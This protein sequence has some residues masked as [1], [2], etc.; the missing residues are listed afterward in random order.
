MC[1]CDA[2][3]CFVVL[4][5]FIV[6]STV[7]VVVV[8]L[9]LNFDGCLSLVVANGVRLHVPILLIRVFLSLL[10]LHSL[11]VVEKRKTI[12]NKKPTLF[13]LT[14]VLVRAKQ[15]KKKHR[16][17]MVALFGETGTATDAVCG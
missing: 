2:V 16:V 1:V 9:I 3:L 17:I 14:R 13:S 15:K 4:H 10:F 11:C 5:G 8:V 7:V 12:K 6:F